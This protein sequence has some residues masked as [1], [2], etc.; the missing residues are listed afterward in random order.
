MKSTKKIVSLETLCKE[1][2][3]IEEILFGIFEG[4]TDELLTTVEY[5]STCSFLI[6]QYYDCV[7]APYIYMV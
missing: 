3:E 1:V 7:T 4:N 2:T 6:V 5:C